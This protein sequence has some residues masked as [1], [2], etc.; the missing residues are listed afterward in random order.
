VALSDAFPLV[1]LLD[2]ECE[3]EYKHSGFVMANGNA[4]SRPELWRL[5]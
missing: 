4:N 1:R 3:W 5:Y 2:G